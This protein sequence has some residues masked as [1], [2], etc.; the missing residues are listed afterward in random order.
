[1]RDQTRAEFNRHRR[2]PRCPHRDDN[3]L[4]AS[5][6]YDSY[7]N[8]EN[9]M[10]TPFTPVVRRL[11]NGP[12]MKKAADSM[13]SYRFSKVPKSHALEGPGVRVRK[14]VPLLFCV[15]ILQSGCI[16]L[17]IP[18]EER[19]VLA[20]KPVTEEQL[21]FL[22]AGATT[23][24]EVMTRLGTP[25]VIWEEA[26]LFAYNWEMRQGILLWA[27]GAYYSGAAGM[28]DI[29]KHYVL[30]IQFDDQD[31]VRRFDRAVRSPYKSYGDFLKD[32]VSA[33]DRKSSDELNPKEY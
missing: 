31:R 2:I 12:G 21:A 28:S 25:D 17:P 32:W 5:H 18:V 8:V 10:V 13:T 6:V 24:N 16:F 9:P 11:R 20:G 29:P 3:P 22:T 26:R 30:I 1:M 23:K 15:L 27:V 14:L 19:K 33:S 4:H 7:A